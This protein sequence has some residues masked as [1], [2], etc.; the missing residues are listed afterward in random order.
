VRRTAAHSLA[1]R[2][3][4]VVPAVGLVAA[5]S[6]GATGPASSSTSLYAPTS[7]VVV[8]VMENRSFASVMSDPTMARLAA[9][10][11]LAVNYDAV[12]HPSL[13]NYLALAG[14]STFG[15]TSDC[16][17][18]YVSAPN[19]FSQLAGAHVTYDAYLEGAPTPCYLAPWGGTDYAAKH[20]PFRYFTD[21]R[22]SRAL[23]SHLRPYSDLA[24]TLARPAAA[25][26]HFIWVTP[27][28]CH[29]G[30][31]CS[32]PVAATWLSA[33]V[34]RVTASAAYRS[35]GALI[36]TWDEGYGSSGG[37]GQVATMLFSTSTTPGTRVS[38]RLTHYSLLAT[39]EDVFGLARLGHAR[40]ARTLAPLFTRSLSPGG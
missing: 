13:P 25:V 3:R 9:R 22:T 10:G 21:V 14:G 2:V 34:K 11:A 16:V 17:T 26:P 35:G 19:L 37:G 30:H 5:M 15:V 33:F 29:D 6:L 4:R 7:H 24:R 8:V 27:D 28:L 23:C 38:A 12:A 36:V 40:G 18:C 1:R 31:D 20:N 39:V 32:T